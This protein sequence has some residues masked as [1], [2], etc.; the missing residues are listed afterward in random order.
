MREFC[1]VGSF[2]WAAR[3]PTGSLEPIAEN[4]FLCGLYSIIDVKQCLV[5]SD[6]TKAYDVLANHIRRLAYS[7]VITFAQ[8]P[9]FNKVDDDDDDDEIS[10]LR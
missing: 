7:G 3:C 2:G 5:K 4:S 6:H 10:K 8:A 9:A 1:I